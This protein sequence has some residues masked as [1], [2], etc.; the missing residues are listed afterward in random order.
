M[1]FVLAASPYS[2]QSA[3]TVLKLASAALAAGHRPAI[4]A[5]GDGR[6]GIRQRAEDRRRL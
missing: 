3:A 1:T 4:F 2:G 5:T 6:L